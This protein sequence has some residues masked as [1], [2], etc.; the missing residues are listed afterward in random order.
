[1]KMETDQ[2][3]RR[4]QWTHWVRGFEESVKLRAKAFEG[5]RAA[6]HAQLKRWEH[7]RAR[8]IHSRT[9]VWPSALTSLPNPSNRTSASSLP[10]GTARPAAKPTLHGLNGVYTL[11]GIESP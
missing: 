4:R 8:E 2:E 3:A 7:E 10:A 6:R 1:M 5:D 9:G 11:V